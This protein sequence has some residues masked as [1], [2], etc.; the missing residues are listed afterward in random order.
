MVEEVDWGDEE[1]SQELSASDVE[2]YKA[3]EKK[4]DLIR[5]V[6]KPVKYYSHSLDAPPYYCNCSKAEGRCILCEQKI[7]RT[8][9]I[10]C[11]VVHIADKPV[12]GRGKYE[13]VGTCKTW[14]FGKDKWN[15]LCGIMDDYAKGEK[16]WLKKQDLIITCTDEQFQKLDIRPTLQESQAKKDMMH[17][18]EPAKKQLE[19]Y[20]K[21]SDLNRQ[22]EVLGIDDVEDVEI[23]DSVDVS[24]DDGDDDVPF[25]VPEAEESEERQPGED[26]VPEGKDEVD[27]ILD[28]IDSN[29]IG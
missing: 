3:S 27:D 16:G 5:I 19:F 17:N 25:D 7:P 11:V 1:T 2:R 6:S 8:V 15:T 21:P 26:D 23:D 12:A 14:L 9:K 18:F 10:G 22:K 4:K 20:S 13:Q 24:I 29:G 28:D